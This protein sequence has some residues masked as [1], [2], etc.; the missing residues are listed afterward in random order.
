MRDSLCGSIGVVVRDCFSVCRAVL[1]V[2]VHA[3]NA[4]MVEAL[5]VLEGCLLANNL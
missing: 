3:V 4:A 2:R 1:C 5:A